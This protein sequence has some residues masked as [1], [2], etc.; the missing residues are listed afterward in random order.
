MSKGYRLPDEPT[1]GGLGNIVVHPAMPLLATMFAGTWFAWPWFI[2]NA[3]A[4]GSPT[5]VRETVLALGGFVGNVVIV[6]LVLWLAATFALDKS[7]PYLWTL[8]LVWRLG[9]S[10]QLV[11]LQSRGFGVYQY[12]GGRVRNGLI[13][14]I[15]AGLAFRE[16]VMSWLGHFEPYGWLLKVVF[17]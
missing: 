12:Y 6:M 3:W 9:L 10:Y 14:A 17:A 8:L 1:P 5:R 4:L 2:V 11:E 13:V 16:P 15:G 7:V